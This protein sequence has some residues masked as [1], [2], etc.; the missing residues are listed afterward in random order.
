MYL[1]PMSQSPKLER[2]EGLN[3]NENLADP[4]VPGRV[5]SRHVRADILL[6]KE[7]PAGNARYV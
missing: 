1:E 5:C 3:P 6:P 7:R 4:I 2:L